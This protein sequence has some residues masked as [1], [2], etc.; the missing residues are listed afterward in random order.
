M[1]DRPVTHEESLGTL[2]AATPALASACPALTAY[3]RFR[4]NQTLYAIAIVDA[5]DRPVGLLNRFKFLEALSRPFQ[6]DLFKHQTVTTVMD[7]SPL[8]VDEHVSLDV[9]SDAL[10]DDGSRYIF[11]GFIVTRHGRYLG[12]GTGYSVMRHL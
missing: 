2:I 1:T 10:M 4:D 6:H 12:I 3:D 9:L 5:G 11:D 8:I 7:P